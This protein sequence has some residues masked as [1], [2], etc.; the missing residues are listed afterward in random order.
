MQSHNLASGTASLATFAALSHDISSSVASILLSTTSAAIHPHLFQAWSFPPSPR[1]DARGAFTPDDITYAAATSALKDAP[2]V[3]AVGV[4]DRVDGSACR[5]AGDEQLPALLGVS[6]CGVQQP[7]EAEVLKQPAQRSISP[8][9]ERRKAAPSSPASNR[10]H[11]SSELTSASHHVY[12]AMAS[13]YSQGQHARCDP[14][15]GASSAT[16]EPSSSPTHQSPTAASR[17]GADIPRTA[18]PSPLAAPG[19]PHLFS[20]KPPRPP[21]HGSKAASRGLRGG[22]SR[23]APAGGAGRLSRLM[24]GR[25]KA[26][27][28][29]AAVMMPLIIL[30]LVLFLVLTIV[31]AGGEGYSADA[32][33]EQEYATGKQRGAEVGARRRGRKL[34]ADAAEER[35]AEGTWG[36]ANVWAGEQGEAEESGQVEAEDMRTEWQGWADGGRAGMWG[37]GGGGAHARR[38]LSHAVSL[39]VSLARHLQQQPRAGAWGEAHGAGAEEEEEEAHGAAGRGGRVLA[40]GALK[41]AAPVPIP[42]PTRAPLRL[43]RGMSLEAHAFGDLYASPPSPP[44]HA[45]PHLKPAAA[46]SSPPAPTALAARVSPARGAHGLGADGGREGPR[47]HGH[48]VSEGGGAAGGVAGGHGGAHGH[49]GLPKPPG[50]GGRGGAG[51]GSSSRR[52]GRHGRSASV[53][54]IEEGSLGGFPT[55]ASPTR[56]GGSQGG[57]VTGR[58]QRGDGRGEQRHARSGSGGSAVGGKGR[59][60]Q[61]EVEQCGEEEGVQ[62]EDGDAVLCGARGAASPVRQSPPPAQLTRHHRQGSLPPNLHFL[63]HS[64]S[65]S[66]PNSRSASPS[67]LIPPLPHPPSS[68][69]PPVRRR[70]LQQQQQQQQV[71]EQGGAGARH[72]SVM[73]EHGVEARLLAAREGEG[74]GEEGE[75]AW[76]KGGAAALPGHGLDR[77]APAAAGGAASEA[78]GASG[79]RGKSGLGPSRRTKSMAFPSSLPFTPPHPAATTQRSPAREQQGD[80]HNTLP[81]S[82]GE[83]RSKTSPLRPPAVP[84]RA[85]SPTLMLTAASTRSSRL[86]RAGRS[87]GAGELARLVAA[88]SSP[89]FLPPGA[90]TACGAGKDV[91]QDLYGEGEAE[92]EG[93]GEGWGA[94]RGAERQAN[95]RVHEVGV[96]GDVVG[97]GVQGCGVPCEG[98]VAG[99]VGWVGHAGTDEEGAR[100]VGGGGREER[101][102]GKKEGKKK[103]R[104]KGKSVDSMGAVAVVMAG[105]GDADDGGSGG[106]SVRG[107]TGKQRREGSKGGGSAEGIGIPAA[108]SVEGEGEQGAGR[109]GRRERASSAGK[110]GVAQK[111]QHRRHRTE[112]LDGHGSKARWGRGGS[113]GMQGDLFPAPSSPVS[114]QARAAAAAPWEAGTGGLG[115]GGAGAGGKAGRLRRGLSEAVGMGAHMRAG[116]MDLAHWVHTGERAQGKWPRA[117]ESAALWG[118]MDRVGEFPGEAMVK[119]MWGA[120]KVSAPRSGGKGAHGATHGGAEERSELE[121]EWERER[122][123]QVQQHGRTRSWVGGATGQRDRG[124]AGGEGGEEGMRE[125]SEEEGGKERAW[126]L[127]AQRQMQRGGQQHLAGHGLARW[128]SLAPGLAAAQAAHAAH[129]ALGAHAVKTQQTVAEAG[130]AG[131]ASAGTAGGSGTRGQPTTGSPLPFPLLAGAV[132]AAAGQAGAVG[133]VRLVRAVG[134]SMSVGMHKLSEVLWDVAA[135]AAA[136]PA[137]PESAPACTHSSIE[138]NAHASPL[139]AS[140]SESQQQQAG[141]ALPH[142]VPNNLLTSLPRLAPLTSPASSFSSPSPASS[143]SSAPSSRSLS[144]TLGEGR[145]QGALAHVKDEEERDG[146]RRQPGGRAVEH[147]GPAVSPL[148]V[149]PHAPVHVHGSTGA[150][151]G[152]GKGMSRVVRSTSSMAAITASSSLLAHLLAAASSASPS[153]TAAAVVGAASPAVARLEGGPAGALWGEGER[154]AGAAGSGAG[155]AA[156]QQREGGSACSPSADALGAVPGVEDAGAATEQQGE[157]GE[158]GQGAM[159]SG[160]ERRLEKMP[161]DGFQ[162]AMRSERAAARKGSRRKSRK[163]SSGAST[164]AAADAAGA[165]AHGS[166]GG[167]EDLEEVEGADGDGG[168]WVQGSRDE[169]AEVSVEEQGV[170]AGAGKAVRAEEQSLGASVP[171]SS[172]SASAEAQSGKGEGE[173]GSKAEGKGGGKAGGKVPRA[174]QKLGRGGR[175]VLRRGLSSVHEEYEVHMDMQLGSGQFGVIRMAQHRESGEKFACKSISKSCLKSKADADDIRREV[176]ILELLADHPHVARLHAAFEDHQEVHL[177]M[178][179]CRGGELFDRLKLVGTYS[180]REAA[181]LL[182]TLVGVLQRC[183]AMGVVHRDVKPENILLVSKRSHT[184]IKLIDFGVAAFLK[185]GVELS[186]FVGSH[187]YMA[188]EVIEGQ[189]GAEADIWSA[190][191]VLYVLLSGVPP[192]W[193]K[194]EEG[195]L[196]AILDCH[197]RFKA[198]AWR[199][200]SDAVKHLL[201]C[202]LTRSR[203]ARIT[204]EGILAHP[205]MQAFSQPLP[206]PD[207]DHWWRNFAHSCNRHPAA[208]GGG[209]AGNASSSPGPAITRAT[210][211]FSASSAGGSGSGGG[212]RAGGRQAEWYVDRHGVRHFQRRGPLAWLAQATSR[213]TAHGGWRVSPEVVV[214]AVGATGGAAAWVYVSHVQEVPYTQRRHWVLLSVAQ[215]KRIGEEA[216]QEVREQHRDRLLPSTSAEA[217]RVRHVATKIIQATTEHVDPG[218][219]PRVEYCPLSPSSSAPAHHPASTPSPPA[220]GAVG[221]GKQGGGEGATGGAAGEGG[222]DA[223]LEDSEWLDRQQRQA[224]AVRGEGRPFEEHLKGLTWQVAV[225]DAPVLNAFCLP[226]GK[227]VVF[228][229]LLKCCPDDHQLATVI[230]HEVAHIVA[231]HGAER[232]SSAMLVAVVQMIIVNFIVS[233]PGFI[234]T[235][236]DLLISLP[237]SRMHE[238]EADRIGLM[239]MAKAG[240]NPDAAPGVYEMLDHASSGGKERRPA[241]APEGADKAGWGD[242]MSTHPAGTRRAALLRG[243]ASMQEARRVYRE[244]VEREAGVRGRAWGGGDSW[245]GF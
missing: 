48:G 21:R 71:G 37:E 69:H 209:S 35:G 103:V 183:H 159:G 89:S 151:Q 126:A 13:P 139:H 190:G 115:S 211:Q 117:E 110:A 203:T 30:L 155:H 220:S 225:V 226:S 90:W 33:G 216:F 132:T 244:T 242:F 142:S 162:T 11:C 125:E 141:A 78:V 91:E 102:E 196:Q 58:Q 59:A 201:R 105:A 181:V 173:A 85:A 204:A 53:S 140:T 231:R 1:S 75:G 32:R 5:Y 24:G 161:S 64:M 65:P 138:G 195:I 146:R 44:R 128:T 98:G 171:G 3:A 88:A 67:N 227:V 156:W 12:N 38:P 122:G 188:P 14:Q 172:G 208:G 189:Y 18:Y 137:N 106:S 40:A 224:Q 42:I 178:E 46:P 99:E 70:L 222:G 26:S 239:L 82:A 68:L 133:R 176:A 119:G 148:A 199:T 158:G 114:P 2:F 20:A 31:Q 223:L 104:R 55:G 54:S 213:Q 228:S 43:S 230:G 127:E 193:A 124:R 17:G 129:T 83:A 145:A 6:W 147:N 154:A 41:P 186:E 200:R 79:G 57:A 29:E 52:A 170:A 123:R 113:A 235:A 243:S 66:P 218:K 164:D 166:G 191:V 238:L 92:A 198:D 134:G 205:W 74:S 160:R 76:F 168:A 63:P 121:S 194:S 120:S 8:T 86:G 50:K 202:M 245:F 101:V 72:K 10:L 241:P 56:A 217:L 192:F 93:R 49:G 96:G 184:D 175:E 232:M 118:G 165:T 95:G 197:L 149:S 77:A 84:T 131:A 167:D 214:L 87:L 163:H 73:V 108:G 215:E 7:G 130:E 94:G 4:G 23:K 51:E 111:Q 206:A 36:A 9:R 177:I 80:S 207:A 15:S 16:K 240:Y 180:E 81:D 45:A 233:W 109:T 107:P 116:D 219:P 157:V 153:A 97:A 236:S 179:L 182:R 28:G 47:G 143:A 174:K 210:R 61:G 27:G 169:A 22:E 185:P 34:S 136:A 100:E 112:L 144:R 150:R 221:G 25:R 60:G 234:R 19:V 237:F 39:G 62:G 229:G 152:G 212:G 187:Y 135:A